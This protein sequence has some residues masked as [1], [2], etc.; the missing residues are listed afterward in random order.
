MADQRGTGYNQI[1]LTAVPT[2]MALDPETLQQLLDTI[3]RFVR[4]RL[5]PLEGR[6]SEEDAVPPEIVEDMR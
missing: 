6:V 2:P 1:S 5:V 3:Q 4:E